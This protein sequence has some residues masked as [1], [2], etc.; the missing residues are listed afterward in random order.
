MTTQTDA[1]LVSIPDGGNII[2]VGR[3]TTYQLINDGEL[4]TV[5]I[6]KRRLIVR[7]SIDAYV[8]R[9]RGLAKEPAQ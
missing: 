2:G 9:L 6:R 8:E 3:S 7:S 4:E 1:A 5:K